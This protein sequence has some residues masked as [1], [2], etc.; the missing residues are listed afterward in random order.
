M[1]ESTEDVF[2][3]NGRAGLIGWLP[4]GNPVLIT[5]HRLPRHRRDKIFLT[6]A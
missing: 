1:T 2:E 4:Q 5:D 6:L 3:T